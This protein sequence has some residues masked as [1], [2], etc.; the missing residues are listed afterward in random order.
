MIIGEVRGDQNRKLH[1]R[2]AAGGEVE[3]VVYRGDTVCLSTQ[4]GCAV[5][6]PF[7]A[8]GS[9][10]FFRNLSE[11]ELWHQLA[12]AQG[13]TP[14][15]RVTLSGIGEPLHNWQVVASFLEQGPRRGL[16]VSVTTSGGPVA[17][18]AELLAAP[19]NGVTVSVHAGTEAVRSRLVP[20]GP[21]LADLFGTMLEAVPGLSRRRRKKTALAYLV[22]PGANDSDAEVDAFIGRA[23]PL[24]LAVHLYGLNPVPSAPFAR[25]DRER[26]EEIYARLRAAGLGVRMSSTARLEAVG[27]CG[28]LVA[29]GAPRRAPSDT[30][31]ALGRLPDEAHT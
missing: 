11:S 10:G 24:G 22:L 3:T 20:R 23:A 26:F 30:A 19:H 25:G 14:F 15:R 2:L 16:R 27:G 13:D 9:G 4:V 21:S 17:R 18:L 5:G 8:S 29:Q 1:L 12:I 7:C 6:C 31:S 28:T